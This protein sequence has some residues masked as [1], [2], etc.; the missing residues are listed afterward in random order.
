MGRLVKHKFED[1]RNDPVKLA[2]LRRQFRPCG[3]GPLG[4]MRVAV[5]FMEAFAEEKGW[6]LSEHEE[7]I[8][9]FSS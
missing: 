9:G 2:K 7:N 4:V 8:N 1:V 6:D 3:S 5:E